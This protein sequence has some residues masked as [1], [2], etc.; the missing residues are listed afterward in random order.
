[1]N[2]ICK[3]FTSIYFSTIFQEYYLQLKKYC[4]RNK[5]NGKILISISTYAHFQNLS[6]AIKSI[7]FQKEVEILSLNEIY[8]TELESDMR[9]I[10]GDYITFNTA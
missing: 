6:N 7:C 3:P 8:P 1:M 10:Y 9:I 4:L 5:N 2:K